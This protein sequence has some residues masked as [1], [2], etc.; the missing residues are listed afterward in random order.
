MHLLIVTQPPL[1]NHTK[2]PPLQ[3]TDDYRRLKTVIIHSAYAS[4]ALSSATWHRHG[5]GGTC[6]ETSTS[7]RQRPGDNDTWCAGT[8]PLSGFVAHAPLFIH[9]SLDSSIMHHTFIYRLSFIHSPLRLRR[10][11]GGN[12]AAG[13]LCGEFC[14]KFFVLFC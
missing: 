11:K 6:H 14:R 13:R 4:S 7:S 5:H 2:S 8:T 12:G 1:F 3:L 10:G 9:E